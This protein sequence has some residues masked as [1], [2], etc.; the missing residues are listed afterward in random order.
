MPSKARVRAGRIVGR[1][2]R[3]AMSAR[4]TA[5]RALHCHA[6]ARG[7]PRRSGNS[8]NIYRNCP[9]MSASTDIHLPVAPSIRDRHASSATTSTAS[10]DPHNPARRPDATIRRLPGRP[11]AGA[12]RPRG[13]GLRL[14]SV[15][16]LALT[17]ATA[18][19]AVGAAP[20]SASEDIEFFES[21]IR[22][23]LVDHCYSCHNSIDTAEGGLALDH[24]KAVLKGGRRGP[25]VVPGHPEKS[26]LVAV[27]KHEIDGLEMPQDGGKLP[28]AVIA[29]LE[30]W[31]RRGLPD[32]R[33]RPPTPQEL[34]RET[35]WDRIFQQ[36]L[37][38]WAFQP[39]RRPDVPAPERNGWSNH[40]VDRFI[41]AK[42]REKGLT[43][44]PRAD[45]A[46]LIRRLSF[47]L[48]GLPPTPEE[49]RAFLEDRRPD[50]YERLVERLLQSEHF[51]ER[52]ARHWMDW[53]RYA[54]SHGSEGD[55]RIDNAWYYR[56]YLIRALNDDVP[57]DQL[58][59]EHIAGD[60]L[61]TPRVNHRLGIN[62]SAIGPAHWR[63]VFHGFA[64]TDALD[65]KVRFTDDQ[66]NTFSKAF[67]AL[68]VSCARCHHHKFD[69]ISQQ[70]YYRLFGIFGSCRPARTVIDLPERLAIHRDRLQRLKRRIRNAVAKDWMEATTDLAD[71]LTARVPNDAS[72]KNLG[73]IT[74]EFVA[75]VAPLQGNRTSP[76]GASRLT[77]AWQS[78]REHWKKLCRQRSAG[79][80]VARVH[81]LLND[82]DHYATW[83]PK[84]IGLPARPSPPGTFAVAP[85]GETALVGVYPSG[86]YSH[87]ISAKYPARL[88]SPTVT[89]DGEYDLYVRVI[90][91]DSTVRYVVQN[92][93]RN[94]TVY[95]VT[96]LAPKW[97]L[98]KYDLSYWNGDAIHIELACG[99]DAPLLV[100]NVPRSW[101]GI[102]EVLI[103]PRG[104][105]APPAD[106]REFADLLY[107]DSAEFRHTPQSVREL[108]KR[109]EQITRQA[110]AAWADG[111]A[112][113]AQADWLNR[114]LQEGL[115]PNRL[116]RLPG[117]RP[118]IEQYRQLERQI[119]IARRVPGLDETAGHDQ[120]LFVRGNHKKP[121]PPVPR[122]FLS[123]L[124][125]RPYRT[126]LSGRR[127]L[128]E[129]VARFDN[130]LTYRVIVNR[131][132]HH[133][134]GE[135]IVRT[136][137]NFG[138]LGEPPTHPELLDWLV[139]RFQNDGC[140]IKALIRLLVTS[141][142]WKQSSVASPQARQRDP[143]NRYWSHAMVRRLEAEAIRDSLLATAGR[144]D[145]TLYGPSVGGNSPRRSV[146]VQVIRNNLDPFLRAFGF[147]EP[148]ASVGR[149]N[150]TNVPAQSLMMMNDRRIR[151][152][153][154][155]WADSVLRAS[156]DD[157]E[158]IQRIF[159]QAFSRY[160]TDDESRAALQYLDES[161]ARARRL[162]RR[163][164]ELEDALDDLRTRRMALLEPVR[165]QIELER[166]SNPA[167][168]PKAPSA[169]AHWEF[170]RDFRDSVGS[171]HG[172]PHGSARVESGALLV[173]GR[174]YVLTQP[175]RMELQEK[176]LE[177][178]VELSDLDQRGGGVVSVQTP[179]GREFDAIVFGERQPRQWMAGSEFFRRSRDFANAPAESIRGEPV[180][181]ALV[182]RA[183]GTIE[184]YRNGRPY[185][186]PYRSNGPHRFG[187]GAVIGFGIRH[188]PAGGNKMLRA[189]IHR[190]RLYD[191]ALTAEQIAASFAAHRGGV[192]V[193]D[194]L[195]RLNPDQRATL[196]Q[197]EHE[198][199]R[200][201][202]QR[203]ALGPLPSTPDRRDA[204]VDLA[205]AFFCMK[206]FIYLR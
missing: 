122:G 15:A 134:F 63:M 118:L 51:G 102:R 107:A 125:P 163:A 13:V 5:E 179:D 101:F 128:A 24:R 177:A 126:G 58:V 187:P 62:E 3:T 99:P 44:G 79:Y 109:F 149:R 189:R 154:A 127:E 69:P 94:G 74:A 199:T 115:L 170:D 55:P 111:R 162:Q 157:A 16:I 197:L 161:M 113:D 193:H 142:T 45:R 52:W 36:R 178:W 116:E 23:V 31:I 168:G 56:D 73:A 130:P 188:L 34:A 174:G 139:V 182:Y 160:P 35:S 120:P 155:A 86:V 90:G 104:Q 105:P 93:P 159:L 166:R 164:R 7:N 103:V 12:E 186:T 80:D 46:T 106:P 110:I 28:A 75:L 40:P 10:P 8:R 131:I 48:T 66:I 68:T 152:L 183:D 32:P 18:Y 129:D 200:L 60:L 181:V 54:E 192:T 39:V 147:P 38:W 77:A 184:A 30:E 146:Y 78:R 37:D 156:D 167:A 43:P 143:R 196:Q 117:T 172:T 198:M 180:H 76:D 136:P 140:S 9:S 14:P 70:D 206:E 67:L 83:F 92:Y 33:D 1:P 57:Y 204:W 145:H 26:R 47:A 27:V 190:V 158:R 191:R 138:H 176:T 205:H 100:R 144:L 85:E 201:R 97:R 6:A 150:I 65:E 175:L 21:R 91:Q 108:A 2:G 153:A 72:G 185:G 11:A 165:R 81:W 135:G 96:S 137:N 173:D 25:V 203:A 114:C 4:Q 41:L 22:P 124:N 169:M 19:S 123:A 98:Q 151:Q 171:L 71:R 195:A 95:P 112:S 121:G 50:A 29:D 61:E 20:P 194:V 49:V 84:G 64:P 87:A 53:I 17:V 42:L 88:T 132:W 133:L 119:P 82:S 59:R 202:R 141:E 89:L 148:F